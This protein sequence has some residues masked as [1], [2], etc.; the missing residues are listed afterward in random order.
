V[1][2]VG[3]VKIDRLY[4]SQTQ[5]DPETSQ[6]PIHRNSTGSPNESRQTS[7]E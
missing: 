3:S 1:L 7:P 5:I 4:I 6:L 2:H